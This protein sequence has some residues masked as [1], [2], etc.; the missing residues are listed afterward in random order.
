M[1]QEAIRSGW[2]VKGAQH[3]KTAVTLTL[4]LLLW[5]RPAVLVDP[6]SLWPVGRLL[7]K[8]HP[9]GLIAISAIPFMALSR[10]ASSALAA[11]AVPLQ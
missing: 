2:W 10:Q 9:T 11:L 3:T 7:G 8:M 6:E 1:W 5:G 4:L